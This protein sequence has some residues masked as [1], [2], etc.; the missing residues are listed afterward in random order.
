[1]P[2]RFSALRAGRPLPR[3]RFL[4]GLSRPQG[5]IADGRIRSTEKSNDLIRI[6][7]RDHPACS[8]VRQ[9][10]PYF[11]HLIFSRWLRRLSSRIRNCFHLQ[12]RGDTK[13]TACLA[14]L[15]LSRWMLHGLPKRRWNSTRPQDST[16]TRHIQ[17]VQ[18]TH[19]W[20][21]FTKHA[22]YEHEHTA[23]SGAAI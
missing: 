12:D 14:Y 2:V 10:T 23:L 3:G 8:I 11:L 22:C 6:R 5:H 18:S 21:Y 9:P 16:L 1:M 19:T 20:G 15:R 4:V 13:L 17:P 7:S